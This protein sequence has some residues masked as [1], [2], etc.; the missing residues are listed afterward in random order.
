[1]KSCRIPAVAFDQFENALLFIHQTTTLAAA[2]R[3]QFGANGLAFACGEQLVHGWKNYRFLPGQ[4]GLELARERCRC[5]TE[6]ESRTQIVRRSAKPSS[7]R[8]QLGKQWLVLGMLAPHVRQRTVELDISTEQARQ[9]TNLFVLNVQRQRLRKVTLHAAAR[10]AHVLRG[11]LAPRRNVSGKR[12]ELPNATMTLEQ[13][14]C[15]FC[16]LSSFSERDQHGLSTSRAGNDATS[17]PEG[18]RS[19]SDRD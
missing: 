6:R 9:N 7:A 8:E 13:Q 15:E 17:A 4:V 12:E 11:E 19:A 3:A 16:A 18:N 1:L 10:L 2:T 14:I 5:L